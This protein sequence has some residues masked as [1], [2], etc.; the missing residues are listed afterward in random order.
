MSA[1]TARAIV[2]PRRYTYSDYEKWPEY[3][4][5]EL[6]NGRAILLS[7]P[8]QYHQGMLIEL[9]T[10]F[11]TYLRGKKCKV[12]LAPFDVRLNY[13][14][15][16]NTVLQPD[17]LVVRD[18]DKLNGKHCLG[19]PDMVAEILSPSTA[20][21]DNLVKSKLYRDAG[22]KEFWIIDPVH[23]LVVVHLLENGGYVASY[24]GIEEVIP[25]N[26]LED[27]KIRMADVFEEA[28]PD[29]SPPDGEHAGLDE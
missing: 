2:K 29:A 15:A 7:S 11:R 9:G 27:C 25:V 28:P 22:V 6:I 10:Q 24:Y 13:N 3:P 20:R 12:F 21:K 1:L 5:Y 23:R 19:A 26:V 14:T 16:D 4:R 8:S 18:M 17:L